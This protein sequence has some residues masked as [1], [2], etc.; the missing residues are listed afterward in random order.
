M[1]CRVERQKAVPIQYKGH[2]LA[3]SL[4]L[5]VLVDEKVI[6]ECKAVEHYNPV[7]GVQ[8]LT[9]LRLSGLKLALV[10]NFN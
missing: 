4:R 6:V 7:Y 10:I 9:Y 5:D 1:G 3:T 2:Q 8:A